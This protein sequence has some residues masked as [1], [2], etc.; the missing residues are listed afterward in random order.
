[1]EQWRRVQK[2]S[3]WLLV[4]WPLVLFLKIGIPTFLL[5]WSFQL[6]LLMIAHFYRQ[7][8]RTLAQHAH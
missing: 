6:L 8:Y 3:L 4:F 2:I 5:V 1:M 7:H